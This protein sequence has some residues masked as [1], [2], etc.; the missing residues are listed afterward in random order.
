MPAGAANGLS[1]WPTAMRPRP[2]LGRCPS[3]LLCLLLSDAFACTERADRAPA[4]TKKEDRPGRSVTETNPAGAPLPA[5]APVPAAAPAPAPAQP[6]EAAAPKEAAPGA[7]ASPTAEKADDAAARRQ[8]IARV[9]ASKGALSLLGSKGSGGGSVGD[10]LGSGQGS[11]LEAIGGAGGLG[12]AKA[13]GMGSGG[14]GGSP[15]AAKGE[16]PTLT[17][18]PVPTTRKF[19]GPPPA[20]LKTLGDVSRFIART[21]EEHEYEEVGYFRYSD[22]FSIATRPERIGP[23]ARPI[24]DR[25]WPLARVRRGESLQSLQELFEVDGVEGDRYRSF[26]FLCMSGSSDVDFSGGGQQ[27]WSLWKT[28][29]SNP[30]GDPLLARPIGERKL[31]VLIYELSQDKGGKVLVSTASAN[32]AAQHLRGAGL[33]AFLR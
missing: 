13:G 30:E 14:S 8:Q 31:Y 11:G 20:G 33:V 23:D 3:V 16:W 21:L 28:G 2:R 25:R 18:I 4:E 22:G 6:A 1:R 26:V 17:G 19:L 32:T 12:V 24:G 7:A 10:I 15:P 5:P 29:S 9:A 27:T